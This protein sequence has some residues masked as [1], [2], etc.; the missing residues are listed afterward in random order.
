MLAT[1]DRQWRIQVSRNLERDLPDEIC[2]ELGDQSLSLYKQGK[3]GEGINKYVKLIIQR[4]E[5][6]RGFKL[7]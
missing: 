4:L 2:K 7:G 5:K 3:Y 1:K 6:T